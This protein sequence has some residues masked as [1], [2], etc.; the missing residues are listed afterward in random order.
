MH[1]LIVLVCGKGNL[2]SW[3]TQMNYWVLPASR[4]H[5]QKTP[6]PFSSIPSLPG[7]GPEDAKQSPWLVLLAALVKPACVCCCEHLQLE[8][9]K[10]RSVLTLFGDLWVQSSECS[11]DNGAGL[12]LLGAFR[13]FTLLPRHFVLCCSLLESMMSP[14]SGHYSLKH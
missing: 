7:S 5:P 12:L 9:A 1:C 11:W 2:H 8:R 4:L 14:F 3:I 13:I 6:V 10:E